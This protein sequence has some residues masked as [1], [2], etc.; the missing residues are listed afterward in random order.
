MVRDIENPQ[1][2]EIHKI[3]QTEIGKKDIIK[4]LVIIDDGKCFLSISDT[5]NQIEVRVIQEGEAE[6]LRRIYGR[7]PKVTY[8]REING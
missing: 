2:G 8:R 5:N 7:T 6:L 1:S 4:S 3:L